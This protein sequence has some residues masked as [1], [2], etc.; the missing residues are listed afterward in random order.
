MDNTMRLNSRIVRTL[1]V[2]LAVLGVVAGAAPRAH[3]AAYTYGARQRTIN[4]GILLVDNA[5]TPPDPTPYVFF[6]MNERQDLKPFGWNIVNPIAPAN[7]TGDILAVRPTYTLNQTITPSMAPYWEVSLSK[8]SLA[9]LEKF[10]VLLLNIS[11]ANVSFTDDEINTL[12]RYVDNGGQLWVESTGGTINATDGLFLDVAFGGAASGTRALF[13]VDNYNIPQPVIATPYLLSP[14]ELNG[15]GYGTAAAAITGT[16]FL[17]TALQASGSPVI[18]AGQYGAGQVIVDGVD[19]VVNINNGNTGPYADPDPQHA[20]SVPAADLKFAYD[21]LSWSAAH[22]NELKSSHQSSQSAATVGPALT[23]TWTYG[24]NNLSGAATPGAAVNGSFVYVRTA[25]G[26]LRAFNATPG[27]DIIGTGT[28]DAGTADY[29][30]GYPYDEVWDTTGRSFSG[31]TP[32]TLTDPLA[33]APTVAS[34]PGGGTDVFIV[35]VRGQVLVYDAATG[36]AAGPSP[37]AGLGSHGTF[38]TV[39]PA[40]TYFDG[41]IYAGE[42]DGS[43]YVYDFAT[44]TGKDYSLYPTSSPGPTET[45]IA[46]PTVGLVHEAI[47][48]GTATGYVDDI[49]VTVT[50]NLNT[51]TVHAGARHDPLSASGTTYTPTPVNTSSPGSLDILQA[52]TRTTYQDNAGGYQVTPFGSSVPAAPTP[53]FTISSM[54]A[55]P[56]YGDYN[57]DFTNTGAGN[58]VRTVFGLGT[59]MPAVTGGT[60]SAPAL[61]SNGNFYYTANVGTDSTIVCAHDG[62]SNEAAP[63]G[64]RSAMQMEWRFRLPGA[65]DSVSLDAD[66][67]S[68]SAL[69]GYQFVGTPVVDDQGNVFALATDGANTAVLCFNATYSPFIQIPVNNANGTVQINQLTQP[70]MTGATGP[71][72]FGNSPAQAV[73]V[74]SQFSGRVDDN[75]QMTIQSFG[76]SGATNGITAITP[77][78]SEPLPVQATYSQ[79]NTGGTVTNTVTGLFHTNLTWYAI[80]PTGTTIPT[81]TSL[82]LVGDYL[83]FPGTTPVSGTNVTGVLRLYA[84]PQGAGLVGTG[85]VYNVSGSPGNRPAFSVAANTQIGSVNGV[86]SAGSGVFVAN[87]TAGVQAFGTKYSLVADANRVLEVDSDG[88]PT[89]LVDATSEINPAT[90]RTTTVELNHPNSIT[91][92]TANDYLVADTGNNRCVRFDRAGNVIW[93]LSRFNDATLSDTTPFYINP[94][95]PFAPAYKT[96]AL[97]APGEP[98]TLNHPTSVT[99]YVQTVRDSTGNTIQGTIVHYLIADTGN[100]RIVE[101]VDA[102]DQ[103]GNPV[104]VPHDLVWVSRTSDALGR[105]Y[106]YTS[107]NYF[108]GPNGLTYI[109]GLVSNVRIAGPIPSPGQMLSVR[110]DAPGSSIALLDY[111]PSN[112]IP[113]QKDGYISHTISAYLTYLNSNGTFDLTDSPKYYSVPGSNPAI[114]GA[115][116]PPTLTYLRN[117]RL[118]E[119]YTPQGSAGAVQNFLLADD[120]GVYD[121]TLDPTGANSGATTAAQR[122][123]YAYF[124]E[125]TWGFT[126]ADYQGL[127][128]NLPGII[129]A[130]TRGQLN[131]P[132]RPN[133]LQRT[134]TD[135]VTT[136][137]TTY[138]LGHYLVTNGFSTGEVTPVS[139]FGGEVLELGDLGLSAP[140]LQTNLVNSFGNFAQGATPGIAA[141]LSQPTFAAHEK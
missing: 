20:R 141:P 59:F 29:V 43:L 90:K 121:L 42:P 128:G 15:L 51:Y 1:T 101:V 112:T 77:N 95:S 113:T 53:S 100:N 66:G 18:A 25:D 49:V 83:F 91:Q 129:P 14:Q 11:S 38:T 125:A 79:A 131:L 2:L 9:N 97:L 118:L 46:S 30:N 110:Q 102:F 109:V 4:A 138:L 127:P 41:R 96:N 6:I 116:A 62:R 76:I 117:P 130:V 13:P 35:N 133:S 74:G 12:R 64:R 56:V 103:N 99:S 34:V 58:A 104:G 19:S 94:T 63:A 98:T 17:S 86:L 70:E 10:D 75:G 115:T 139:G 82:T 124:L 134:G 140:A 16:S 85:R 105:H 68:Y 32:V 55:P 122:T 67:I 119:T 8:T 135:P 78:L 22:P 5:G 50:T 132:F 21:I 69:T 81:I 54:P 44:G 126:Q 71:D 123:A 60:I 107:A 89:W 88:V 73:P 3:A 93:E 36:G 45:A 80:L 40:P 108:T 106:A 114:Q 24:F 136:G 61:D 33:S 65:N 37:L 87:G 28:P 26:V 111:D 52:G 23:T 120:N 47:N 72:E 39:A 84:Y 48:Q 27:T 137:G 7:V 57:V 92:V 31:I